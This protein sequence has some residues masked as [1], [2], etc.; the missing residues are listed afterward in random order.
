M[1]ILFAGVSKAQIVLTV[2]DLNDAEVINE[3]TLEDLDK[4][5]QAIVVTTNEFVDGSAE[6][7]GPLARDVLTRVG[8]QSDQSAKFVAINEYEIALPIEEFFEYDV[9]LATRMEGELLPRRTKG[10]IWL[11]YPMSDH[12]ELQ[13]ARF[14]AKLI[15]QVEK[16]EVQ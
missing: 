9:I 1:A 8:A 4:L 5:T 12:P 15:W 14:N 10:P 16:I 13:D 2:T 6:F 3:Y 7:S 11:I